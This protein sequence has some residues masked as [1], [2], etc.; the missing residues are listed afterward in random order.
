MFEAA[1]YVAFV[2]AFLAGWA[3]SRVQ[4]IAALKR[5]HA[6]PAKAVCETCTHGYGY[7]EEGRICRHLDHN[8][9][10]SCGCKRYVGPDPLWLGGGSS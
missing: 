5:R 4:T 1:D 10:A 9:V 3:G 8:L 7:H 6:L 2:A